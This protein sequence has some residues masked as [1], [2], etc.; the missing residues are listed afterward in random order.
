MGA[1]VHR[2]RSALLVSV[3]ECLRDHPHDDTA[4]KVAARL[5][6]VRPADV[7]TAFAALEAEGL[8]A[9]ADAYWQL[10][11]HGWRAAGPASG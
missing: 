7:E 1:K 2:P 9:H 10:N 11:S 5:G 6:W 8:L 4:A 3:L